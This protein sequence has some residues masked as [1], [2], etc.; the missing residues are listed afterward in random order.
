MN[1][2]NLQYI[3]AI[4]AEVIRLRA[5]GHP[6]IGTQ[7]DNGQLRIVNVTYP[8]GSNRAACVVP[9]SDWQS[10]EETLRALRAMR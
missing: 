9:V 1:I 6:N 5:N 2:A 10:A 3:G 4:R 7:A 8:N